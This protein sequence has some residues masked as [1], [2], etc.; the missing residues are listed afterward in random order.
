MKDS[1]INFIYLYREDIEMNN[2]ES[3]F[4]SD[5]C[6]SEL[7]HIISLYLQV[8]KTMHYLSRSLPFGLLMWQNVN[9]T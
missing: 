6:S 3:I 1:N 4:S 7:D 5:F 9:N 2:L 8:D